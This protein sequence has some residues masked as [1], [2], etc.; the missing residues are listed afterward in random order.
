[1][2]DRKE[3]ILS[4]LCFFQSILLPIRSLPARQVK[5]KYN[6]NPSTSMTAI[7]TAVAIKNTAELP[8]SL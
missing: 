4:S 5:L 2:A 1:M 7:S 3:K 6:Q 8:A